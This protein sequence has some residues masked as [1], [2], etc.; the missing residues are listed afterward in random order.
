MMRILVTG[1]AGFIGSHTVEALLSAG[2]DAI[3]LDNLVTGRRAAVPAMAR[4]LEGDV[5]DAALLDR[6]LPGVDAVLHLAAFTSVPESFAAAAECMDV[7]VTGT[8]TLLQRVARHGCRR[9]VF[10]STSAIYPGEPP[11]AKREEDAPDPTSPYAASKLAGEHLVRAFTGPGGFSGLPLR[12]FNVYGPRQPAEGDGAAVI[13]VFVGRALEG[14]PLTIYG[15]GRQTRDF[16]YVGDVAQA[17]VLALEAAH[18]T[19]PLNI[20]SG[21]AVLIADLAERIRAATRSRSTV[22]FAPRRPGDLEASTADP[23]RARTALGWKA[24]TDLTEGLAATI[25][26][27]ADGAQDA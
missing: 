11:T 2:H 4:F 5:R 21:A 8:A 9:V 1:G 3:V 12:Y 24:E 22:R 25:A 27:L 19:A 26:W 20:G 18:L 15:T 14:E 16:V 7:N 13:P 10:A 23:T 6:L 17:N